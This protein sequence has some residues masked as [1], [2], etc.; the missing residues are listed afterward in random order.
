MT[1]PVNVCTDALDTE[2]T[3]EQKAVRMSISSLAK[4][5]LASAPHD[6]SVPACRAGKERK[7]WQSA[8]TGHFRIAVILPYTTT[9][10]QLELRRLIYLN[11]LRVAS[12]VMRE[13]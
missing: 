3:S 12:A 11:A 5:D 4:I 13:V 7:S 8:A 6:F 2:F 10:T 9:R 1:H